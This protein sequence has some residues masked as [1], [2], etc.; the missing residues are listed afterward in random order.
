MLI[1]AKNCDESCWKMKNTKAWA[2][3]FA[4]PPY[5]LG[6]GL[7]AQRNH[8]KLSNIFII[9]NNHILRFGIYLRWWRWDEMGIVMCSLY[10]DC[11][12]TTCC[13]DVMFGIHGL[14]LPCSLHFSPFHFKLSLIHFDL[15]ISISNWL[16]LIFF[17]HRVK[18]TCCHF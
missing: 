17:P 15:V 14:I 18:M 4:P 1:V 5:K 7:N 6:L 8:I 11:D 12:E 2:G 9:L 13:F 10:M 16:E 3:K